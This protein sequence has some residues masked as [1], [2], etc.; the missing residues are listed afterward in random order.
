MV[1]NNNKKVS[2][3]LSI[4]T[5]T[6]SLTSQPGNLACC[7]ETTYFSSLPLAMNQVECIDRRAIN[8]NNSLERCKL[9][10]ILDRVLR[11]VHP[12]NDP[13]ESAPLRSFCH[14]EQQPRA[15][16]LCQNCTGGERFCNA[17][18]NPC[19]A[20]P[21]PHRSNG[22]DGRDPGNGTE[23]ERPPVS[24]RKVRFCHRVEMMTRQS[25]S[26]TIDSERL[27]PPM[28]TVKSNLEIVLP[29]TTRE[30]PE[31]AAIDRLFRPPAVARGRISAGAGHNRWASEEGNP[32]IDHVPSMPSRR[33][34]NGRRKIGKD[35]G[36][37]T[38]TNRRR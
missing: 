20:N 37:G 35:A 18:S 3:D 16:P 6:P 15:C 32:P 21:Q 23:R 4:L 27:K 14:A 38:R 8:D 5:G 9:T 19:G 7:S 12:E 10:E 30:N 28:A 29:N 33:G 2:L 24:A 13:T 26:V 11:M 17:S 22:H 36:T 1:S 25:E 34:R 31:G